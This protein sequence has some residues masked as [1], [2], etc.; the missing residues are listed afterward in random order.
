MAGAILASLMIGLTTLFPVGFIAAAVIVANQKAAG[1]QQ[2]WAR[3]AAQ[4]GLQHAADHVYGRLDGR[5]VHVRLESRGGGRSRATYTVVSTPFSVPLD[6]GLMLGRQNLLDEAFAGLFGTQAIQ[7]GDP[8]FDRAIAV[9]ADEPARAAALLI[10]P[11]RAV[12]TSVAGSGAFHLTDAGFLIERA[13]GIADEAWISWALRTAAIVS[14]QVESA[15]REVPIAAPLAAV[16]RP[17][18]DF[19]AAHGLACTA[20]PLSM[21]GR[22][23]G[24]AITAYAA[25]LQRLDFAL[26][27]RVG[28]EEIL[29]MGLFVRPAG[30][31]DGVHQLFGHRPSPRGDPEFDRVFFVQ[32]ADESKLAVAL[33]GEVQRRMLELARRVGPLYVSDEGV[34]IQSRWISKNPG[35]ALWLVEQVRDL[36]GKIFANARGLPRALGPYR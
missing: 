13:G 3:V 8:E 21:W 31:F 28:F 10:R 7:V 9:K 2:A 24:A 19:A 35:D 36:G 6:L 17:W 14:K 11:L 22:L 1:R 34:T 23:G 26:E 18:A 12:L 32:A 16:W 25:R 29:G 20:T 33:D 27:V 30:F 15:R 4:L 5:E